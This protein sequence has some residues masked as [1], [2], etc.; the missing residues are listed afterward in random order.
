[1]EIIIA[2]PITIALC[3]WLK[4]IWDDIDSRKE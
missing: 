2:I 4:C 1:M 3:W